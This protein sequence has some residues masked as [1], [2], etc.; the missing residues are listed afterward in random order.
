MKRRIP[1]DKP[2]LSHRWVLK[3]NSFWVAWW[4]WNI[5]NCEVFWFWF[6]CSF[7]VCLMLQMGWQVYFRMSRVPNRCMGTHLI[8]H[9]WLVFVI[10]GYRP[11]D[12]GFGRQKSK[13]NFCRMVN[14]CTGLS[15]FVTNRV[16]RKP[17]QEVSWMSRWKLGSMDRISGLF[18]LYL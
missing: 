4:T 7:G 16:E 17:N 18:H 8:L 13:C 14:W 12:E 2:I 9:A 6:P 3:Q 11:R 15:M 5:N 10:E 1:I